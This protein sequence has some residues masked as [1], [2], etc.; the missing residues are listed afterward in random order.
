M[1]DI[2]IRIQTLEEGHK[3]NASQDAIQKREEEFLVT[4]REIKE[5]MQK[6]KEESGAAAGGSSSGGSSAE[7]TTLQEENDRLHA[8]MI[9]QEYRITHLVANMEKLLEQRKKE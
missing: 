3:F 9:K 7:M 6:E 1:T 2:E 8:K 5:S 4:L